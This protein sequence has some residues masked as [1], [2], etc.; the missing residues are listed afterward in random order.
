MSV[1]LLCSMISVKYVLNYYV[2]FLKISNLKKNVKY[3]KELI[4]NTLNNSADKL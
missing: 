2:D 1:Y 4:R 3:I